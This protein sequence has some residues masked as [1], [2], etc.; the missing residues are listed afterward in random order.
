M[1]PRKSSVIASLM[2]VA[3]AFAGCGGADETTPGAASATGKI[4]APT[5]AADPAAE[6]VKEL[7]RRVDAVKGQLGAVRA[8]AAGLM[9]TDDPDLDGLL[10]KLDGEVKNVE[11]KL[12]AA[13]A[14]PDQVE[15]ALARVSEL[16]REATAKIQEF[17][18]AEDSAR[19]ELQEKFRQAVEGQTALPVDLITGLDGEVYLAYKRS[20]VEQVQQKLSNSRFFRGEIDGNLDEETF[21]SIGRYQQVEGLYVSGIPSPMTRAR[22]FPGAV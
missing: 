9:P 21:V 4:E 1:N 13:G 10:A 8:D 18:T 15:S 12:S 7:T 16:Q 14:D 5:E 17:K 22:L 20:V 19:R 6:R 2:I 3:V 11:R